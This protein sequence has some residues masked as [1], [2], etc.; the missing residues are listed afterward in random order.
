MEG[1]GYLRIGELGRR[2]DVAPEL[3]RAWERRYGLLQPARSA[4]G[5]RL[6]SEDDLERVLRMRGHLAA[7]LSAAEAAALVTRQAVSP[8]GSLGPSELAAGLESF[9]DA[10]AH[11][12]LDR[13]LAEVSLDAV[14]EDVVLPY[15]ADL[16]E[17]WAR[18]EVSVAQEHFATALLRGR[19]LGLAR[20]WGRGGAGHA[21]LAAPPGERHDLGLICF[22]LALRARGTR[23][24]F[25]GADTPAD[26]LLA[27]TKA[28]EPSVVVVAAVA[29]ERFRGL[30]PDLR[31]LAAAAPLALGGRGATAAVAN[32]VGARL[33]DDRL[34]AAADMVAV[35]GSAA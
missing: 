8:A 34:I 31:E 7:G 18:D 33:L 30:Q 13:L 4:G 22:G 5:F 6:Y 24:T 15:L 10:A 23:V 3:L 32:A 9:D 12:T 25:L 17:R 14:L 29:R 20:G 21:L 27:T 35:L 16:G 11:A 2:A 26:T 28:L 19:L 1:R